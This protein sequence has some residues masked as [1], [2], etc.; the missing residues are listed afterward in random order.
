MIGEQDARRDRHTNAWV[1][2]LAP[3]MP[4]VVEKDTRIQ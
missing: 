4:A 3:F 2:E 1:V